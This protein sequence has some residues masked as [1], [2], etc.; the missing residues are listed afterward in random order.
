MSEMYK[1]TIYNVQF[2][3]N[4]IMYNLSTKYNLQCTIY[5]QWNNVQLLFLAK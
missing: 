4:G 5:V 2:M 1:C 3:Y